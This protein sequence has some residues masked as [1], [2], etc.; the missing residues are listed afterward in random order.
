MFSCFKRNRRINISNHLTS[1]SDLLELETIRE[2][3]STIN[4]LR[5]EKEQLIIHYNNIRNNYAKCRTEL[6]NL[7]D[8][9]TFTTELNEN[10]IKAIIEENNKL[11]ENMALIADA[12]NVNECF[13][14]VICLEN[15]KDT[16][17][18]PCNHLVLCNKCKNK[19][20]DECPICRNNI[21]SFANVYF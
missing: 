10:T 1:N 20:K 2:Y 12:K 6:T 8:Q 21:N 7:C 3:E 9:F 11:V 5:Y 17:I 19:V 13:L 18:L 15:I 4:R 14:C 16:L